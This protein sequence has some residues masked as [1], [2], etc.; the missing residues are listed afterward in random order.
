MA[1]LK[2]Y[3]APWCP[4]CRRSKQFLGE[5]RISY[6][7]IDIDQEPSAAEIVREKNDG[8]QII[9]TIVFP[10]G[11]F[12]AEPSN[13]ELA[14]K[15]G[16]K[17]TA[18]RSFYDLLIVGGGPAGLTAAIYAARGDRP[19]GYREKCPRR[20]GRG[21]RKDRKLPGVSRRRRR[22]RAGRE[23]HRPIPSIRRGDAIGGNRQRYSSCHGQ[24]RA[25]RNRSGR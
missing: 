25:R 9:P 16:L 4:D 15:L 24:L 1:D 11:S 14:Q 21:H 7:W 12:L 23:G 19:T 17:L 10:D 13:S 5:Q 22:G 18:K 8:K 2:V 3:G 20:P 6:D